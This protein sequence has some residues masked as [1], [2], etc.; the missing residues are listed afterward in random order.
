MLRI[1]GLT[2]A[3]ATAL[4]A[5]CG[6]LPQDFGDPEDPAT[7]PTTTQTPGTGTGTGTPAPGASQTGTGGTTNP[8]STLPTVGEL[9]MPAADKNG[10]KVLMV[11]A[12]KDFYFQEYI[13]PRAELEAK[14]FVVEVAAKEKGTATPHLGS[15]QKDSGDVKVDFALSEVASLHYAAIVIVGGWGSSQYQFSFD[16]KYDNAEYDNKGPQ[17]QRVNDLIYE[18]ADANKYV[19]AICHGVAVLG[20]AQRDE[21]SFLK[22]HTVT[23]YELGAPASTIAGKHW[24][25]NE[26]TTKNMLIAVGA[27]VLDPQS[28]GDPA[29]DTDD[30]A[31]DGKIV[32]AQNQH[33]AREFGKKLA[34]LLLPLAPPMPPPGPTGP[35]G[36]TGADQPPPL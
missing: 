12:N 7:S 32:T 34:E 33:T 22:D 35:T 13:E 24:D 26:Y 20:Y 9:P 10:V 25:A 11:V 6:A 28:L 14:G 1:W 16:G 30:V 17:A 2:T 31:V 23:A 18:F 36:P 21:V 3:I 4:T 15:G 27:T 5:A 29:T 19:A 8:G